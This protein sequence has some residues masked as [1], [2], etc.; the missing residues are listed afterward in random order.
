MAD[1]LHGD[2]TRDA[3]ALEVTNRRADAVGGTGRNR[4]HVAAFALVGGGF[5]VPAAFEAGKGLGAADN[6]GAEALRR[7][8]E[9]TL[10]PTGWPRTLRPVD[11]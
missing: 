5:G 11:E 6:L 10:K 1:E 4:P 8:T 3:G 2:G 9:G 7:A